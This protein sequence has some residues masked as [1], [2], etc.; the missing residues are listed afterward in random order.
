[1]TPSWSGFNVTAAY[2]SN[3]LLQENGNGNNGDNRV[4]AILPRYT[5]GPLDVGINYHRIK[6]KDSDAV[7]IT[8]WAVGGSYNFGVAKLA[9]I[10]DQNRWSD[11]LG[12]DGDDL[13]LK[14]W[15]L[16]ATFPF[17]KNAVQVS[18][19]QSK[20]DWDN[21]SGKARQLALGYTYALSKRT[22]VYAAIADVH[23]DK[24]RKAAPVKLG[25][26]AA[27][28]SGDSSN[29]GNGYQNGVQFGIKHTF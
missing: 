29:G 26:L 12:T 21:D 20:L 8:N 19:T 2:S 11:V 25:G 6:S 10:Y 4:F 23:N 5:N 15:L 28:S 3:A 1:M 24:S 22:N 18:W 9:V 7:K 27:A 17:G 13:K 16:G 14:S